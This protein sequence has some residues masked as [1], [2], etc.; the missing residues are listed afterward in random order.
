MTEG[1]GVTTGEGEGVG[2]V[3]TVIGGGG[4]TTTGS[5]GLL[6]AGIAGVGEVGVCAGFV[7]LASLGDD[8]VGGVAF[9]GELCDGVDVGECGSVFFSGECCGS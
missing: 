7:E 2:G 8:V 9:D 6:G 5:A 3:G 1:G 4:G